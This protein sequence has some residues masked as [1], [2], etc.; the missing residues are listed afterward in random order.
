MIEYNQSSESAFN[1]TMQSAGSDMPRDGKVRPKYWDHVEDIYHRALE[2]ESS[3][4]A[5]FLQE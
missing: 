1:E 3:A 5:A 2:L 4:R